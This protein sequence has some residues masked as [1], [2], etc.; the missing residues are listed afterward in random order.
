M[1]QKNIILHAPSELPDER[2][3]FALLVEEL[4]TALETGGLRIGQV[5]WAFGTENA[6]FRIPTADDLHFRLSGDINT[7]DLQ[8]VL[9]L[10]VT[11]NAL[12]R[13]ML[14]VDESS[15]L[16]VF[17]KPLLSLKRLPFVCNTTGYRKIMEN[18][19]QAEGK[20]RK[21]ETRAKL[22][23]GKECHKSYKPLRNWKLHS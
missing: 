9:Q 4:N 13:N 7:R 15:N 11:L 23:S 10:Q 21:G 12:Y 19:R 8:F 16:L 17:H 6:D 3:E 18:V 14:S 2:E 5:N 20:S 1:L 22:S